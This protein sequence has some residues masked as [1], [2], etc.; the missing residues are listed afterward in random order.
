MRVLAFLGTVCRVGAKVSLED[1]L[2][3]LGRRIAGPEKDSLRVNLEG[4]LNMVN[5]YIYTH[6]GYMQNKR[7]FSPE[8][9][10]SYSVK[11]TGTVNNKEVYS[12]E[13]KCVKD[14]AYSL[15]TGEELTSAE[16]LRHYH[17]VLIKLFPSV[18]GNLSIETGRNDS[19]TKFLR[20]KISEEE[21]LRVL[22]SLFLLS[23]GVDVP[24]LP[25]TPD[26]SESPE[27]LLSGV[28]RI[29]AR[30]DNKR[31][32]I[33]AVI[34]FLKKYGKTHSMPET[35]SAFESGE[36]LDSTQF[37]VQTYIFEYLPNKEAL[38]GFIR[39]VYEIMVEIKSGTGRNEI[40][41]SL[42]VPSESSLSQKAIF[43][44]VTRVAA[45]EK[46]LSWFPYA[47]TSLVPAYKTVR[48]YSRKDLAFTESSFSNCVETGVYAA[49]CCLAYDPEKQEY[50]VEK[51]L[52]TSEN[53]EES[54]DLHAFFQ[55]KDIS[56]K[57]GA[58]QR[59]L[60]E[61][62]R[63]VSGLPGGIRYVR[64]FG[65]ELEAG[66]LNFL[67]VI[68]QVA[69]RPL[70]EKQMLQDLMGRL[71]RE[72][73]SSLHDVWSA[74]QKYTQELF[75]A[76]SVNKSVEVK[77]TKM[78][79]NS[80]EGKSDFYGTFILKYTSAETGAVQGLSFVSSPN[81]LMIAPIPAS[82]ALSSEEEGGFLA[83]MEELEKKP[84]FTSCL[85]FEYT[86]QC[87]RKFAVPA[88]SF[89]VCVDEFMKKAVE[90]IRTSPTHGVNR[91]LLIQPIRN[92]P[93]MA[94]LT[95]TL[96]LT[97]K[98]S[99]VALDPSHKIVRFVSNV[100]GSS[101]LDDSYTQCTMLTIPMYV[102]DIKTLFPR[103]SLGK[104]AYSQI[105]K[106]VGF[107]LC[108]NSKVYAKLPK[109]ASFFV[110]Y[111]KRYSQEREPGLSTYQMLNVRTWIFSVFDYI[112]ADGSCEAANELSDAL[113]AEG[114]PAAESLKNVLDLVWLGLSYHKKREC[115]GLILELYD[116][117]DAKSLDKKGHALFAYAQKKLVYIQKVKAL[118]KQEEAGILPEE[119]AQAVL[120][121]FREEPLE[122]PQPYVLREAVP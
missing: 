118:K 116:R 13:R 3:V 42:F 6:L 121:L 113:A 37:L 65:N 70:E 52:Q 99:G 43:S 8:I 73:G 23:V 96:C 28:N 115:L 7:L 10:T 58:S 94:G 114:T 112:F 44:P 108:K 20:R 98:S 38:A 72:G 32:E 106:Q 57:H 93:F 31:R 103:I 110:K 11:C 107:F 17:E 71:E 19:T 9:E 76:L 16:Y 55:R 53:S 62:N 27:K 51:M 56:A 45:V 95:S 104:A 119:K 101:P 82:S 26:S 24:I 60:E 46:R 22:A 87:M 4:P 39:A 41:S 120:G 122:V 77:F 29:L 18:D 36:F 66:F 12:C 80:K 14:A 84:G 75:S 97:A 40:F 64:E 105:F 5:A 68:S 15:Q 109:A 83:S 1:A 86:R 92:V 100:L 88:K 30:K 50:N 61:W 85:F 78:E 69:G 49:F 34:R 48:A 102:E 79:K 47:D 111:L 74:A 89:G 91:L 117:V 25:D 2:E 21:A 63:V 81:H 35:L 90:K 54:R 59:V 33:V 67:C